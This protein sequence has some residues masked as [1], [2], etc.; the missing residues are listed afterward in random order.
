MGPCAANRATFFQPLLSLQGNSVAF[1][2][3]WPEAL[4]WEGVSQ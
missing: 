3:P 2:L 4:C 1:I